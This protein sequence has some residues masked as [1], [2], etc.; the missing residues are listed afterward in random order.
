MRIALYQPDIA[1]NTGTI[2]RLGACLETG[3][4]IIEPCGFP[5]GDAAMRR[6]GMDYLSRA[7]VVRHASWD[8][9][10]AGQRGRI[11]LMTTKSALAYTAFAFERE[12]TI[13]LGRESAGVPDDVADA[14]D[15]RVSI[16]MAAGERSL[17]VA[18]A[19]GMALGEALRQ[20][21]GFPST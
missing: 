5:F 9:F 11:V 13:L 7:S 10:R 3:I 18:V 15:A 20:T 19:A 8:A 21:Q 17:N 14:C 16:P 6:A 12:D 4:D 1:T 2:I